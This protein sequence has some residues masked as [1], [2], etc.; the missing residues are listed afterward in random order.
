MPIA[1]LLLVDARREER[2]F[3]EHIIRRHM[4]DW[5]IFQAATPEEAL[6]QAAEVQ[7]DIAL[8]DIGFAGMDGFELCRRFKADKVTA[9]FPIVLVTGQDA[10]AELRLRALD[11]GADDFIPFPGEELDLAIKVRVLVRVKKA[12]DEL[13]R[14]NKR[15]AEFA[16][17]QS[18]ALFEIGERYRLLFDNSSDAVIVFELNADNSY[19]RFIEANETACQWSGYSREEF[20]SRTPRDLFPSDRVSGID[21]RVESIVQH[22]QVFFETILLTRSGLQV[23]VGINARVCEAGGHRAIIAVVRRQGSQKQNLTGNRETDLQYRTLAVQTGQ[24]IYDW[25]VATGE[26]K[27]G[28]AMKQVTG[29][30]PEEADTFRWAVWQEVVHPEDQIRVRSSLMEAMESVGKYQMEYRIKHK[31]G[32]YRYIEDVGVVLADESGRACRVLGAM[33]DITGRVRAEEERRRIEQE[34]QHSQKLESLGVLAGGIAHDFNNILAAIIGL[35]EMCLHDIPHDSET[36]SDLREAL[37]AAHR[38]KDLVKQ[39]LAFSRQ[40]DEARAPLYLHVIAR[41]ALKLMRASSPATIEIIDNVDVHSGAV[42]ANAAQMHQ[43]I[44]NYCTNAVQAMK[45]GGILELR[46]ADVEVDEALALQHPKLHTGPYVKIS[47]MDTGH[48]MEPQVMKRIF[49]PFYTTKGPGEGTGMGLAVVHGIVMGHGGAIHVESVPG[50]G[51]A[52]HTYLPRLPG[53]YQDKEPVHESMP[54]GHECILFVEDEAG[55]VRFGEALLTRLGYRVTV[56]RNGREGLLRFADEPD[57]FDLVLTDQIMPKMTGDELARELRR[58]RP[59][60]PIVLFTG[61]SEEMSKD[62]VFELGIDAIV[63][64]P[65]IAVDLAKRIRSILDGRQALK[66]PDTEGSE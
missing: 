54:F 13:R 18:K 60:V 36:Y 55:I 50:R 37:Q 40:S 45:E 65:I 3:L 47:V 53:V 7:P 63:M 28:G 30:N 16:Q 22:Q 23:Q 15:L 14:T 61:F 46:L 25:N 38:A 10:T 49:D 58:I 20:L 57:R 42:L 41:E 34:M 1:K 62:E 59:D 5:L 33:K 35:T 4:P 56:C 8:C 51:S 19:G 39:I 32:E 11:A 21:G 26:I 44:M 6:A 29:Y 66:N 31:Q 2:A 9:R 52:F 64:K 43:V 27:W 12:E 24:M 17:E 48:G